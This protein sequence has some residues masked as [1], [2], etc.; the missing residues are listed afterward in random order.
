MIKE[1]KGSMMTMLEETENRNKKKLFFKIEIP[2]LQSK[3][4]KIKI[5]LKSPT[6]ALNW[7]KAVDAPLE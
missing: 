4:G 5:Y 1:V 2:V 3:I 6:A 7:R